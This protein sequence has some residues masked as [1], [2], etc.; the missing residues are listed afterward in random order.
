MTDDRHPGWTN[1]IKLD[2]EQAAA[3]GEAYVDACVQV[4]RDVLLRNWADDPRGAQWH[5]APDFQT[6]INRDDEVLTENGPVWLEGRMGAVYRPEGAPPE[7]LDHEH[8]EQCEHV[9]VPF[10]SGHCCDV[11]GNQ[12]IGFRL[13]ARRCVATGYAVMRLLESYTT[14]VKP[15]EVS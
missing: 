11:C 12:Y 13:C 5:P 6:R 10:V 3:Q 2:P 1:R 14:H 9:I 8:S 4:L 15:P 7:V